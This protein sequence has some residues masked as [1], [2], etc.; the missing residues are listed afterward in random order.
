MYTYEDLS[1]LEHAREGRRERLVSRIRG[2]L[3][4]DRSPQ[5][6]VGLLLIPTTACVIGVDSVL[7]HWGLDL[8]PLRWALAF[9][10]AWPVFVF[11]LRWR[12]SVEWHQLH[13]EQL[14]WDY[15]RFDEGAEAA[16]CAPK[17]A[18]RPTLTQNIWRETCNSIGRESGRLAGG[19]IP[20]AI[21]M[22]ALTLGGWTIWQLIRTG[23]SL[24]AHVIVDSEAVLSSPV[25]ATRISRENWLSAALGETYLFFLSLAFASFLFGLSL[26]FFLKL[27]DYRRTPPPHSAAFPH[28]VISNRQPTV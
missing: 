3:R 8:T 4:K 20:M 18:P 9:F 1:D 15:V 6:T 2:W 27:R 22:G 12:A 14:G 16:L 21:F 28:F 26:P 25:L 17:S 10:A 23:P 13:L 7:R 19:G 24:L 5:W 11:L